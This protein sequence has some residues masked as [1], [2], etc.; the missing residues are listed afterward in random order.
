MRILKAYP[1][2][3]CSLELGSVKGTRTKFIGG[4][5]EEAFFN[6]NTNGTVDNMLR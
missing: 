6:I 2:N 1:E 5:I 3:P 4:E